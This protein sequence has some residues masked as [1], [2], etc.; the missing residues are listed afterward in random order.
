MAFHTRSTIFILLSS[1]FMVYSKSFGSVNSDMDFNQ[2]TGNISETLPTPA[3]FLGGLYESAVYLGFKYFHVHHLSEILAGYFIFKIVVVVLIF[4]RRFKIKTALYTIL[5][6][7]FI[8]T[9]Y[10]CFVFSSDFFENIKEAWN[11]K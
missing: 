3:P 8:T 1:L 7:D 2:T 5:F 4:L 11:N 9:L 6:L 10:L